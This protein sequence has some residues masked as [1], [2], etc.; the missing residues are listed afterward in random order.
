MELQEWQKLSEEQ[1]YRYSEELAPHLPQSVIFK[2][3]RF[4]PDGGPELST[5]SIAVRMVRLLLGKL[6]HFRLHRNDVDG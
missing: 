3:W 5:D 6:Y 1:K 2:G 4:Y